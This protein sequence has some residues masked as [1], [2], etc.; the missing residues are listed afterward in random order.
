MLHN[1][2]GFSV[3]ELFTV[4]VIMAV[5]TGLSMSKFGAYLAHERVTKAAVGITDDL[6]MA[7]SVPGRIRR[8][9][10]VWCDTAKMQMLVTD[11]GQTVTYRQTSFGSRYNLKSNNVR[12]YPSSSWIEIYPNGLSSADS[13]VIYLSSN[14]YTRSVKVTKGGM[15]QLR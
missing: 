15:V 10:R 8:P 7:F 9:V 13:M 6:R 12:Y 5:V 3:V 2:R 1:R 4:L 14:G 11:R